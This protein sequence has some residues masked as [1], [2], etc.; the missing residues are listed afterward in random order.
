VQAVSDWQA[1]IDNFCDQMIANQIRIQAI[2]LSESNIISPVPKTM[3]KVSFP[4]LI[5]NS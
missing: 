3:N 5:E 4:I 1:V 2:I